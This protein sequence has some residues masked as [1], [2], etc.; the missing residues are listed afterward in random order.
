MVGAIVDNVFQGLKN[1]I[2]RLYEDLRELVS[3]A[4]NKT[5]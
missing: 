4:I 3:A 5:F 1:D 2:R